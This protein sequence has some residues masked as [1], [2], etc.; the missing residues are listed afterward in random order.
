MMLKTIEWWSA[1]S[2][3]L[4][5]EWQKVIFREVMRVR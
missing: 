4:A 3:A 5:A 2:L 1:F